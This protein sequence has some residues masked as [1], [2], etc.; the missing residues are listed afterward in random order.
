MAMMP[1]AV[2]EMMGGAQAGGMPPEQGAPQGGMPP[3]QA[4]PTEPPEQELGDDEL[5]G[6]LNRGIEAVGQALYSNRELSD[7]ILKMVSDKEKIGSAA[8]AAIL[9][10][11]QVDKK[12]D[13]DE[14]ALAGLTVWTVGRLIE[15][16]EA[17]SR[18][19][20]EY[21]DMET[22]QVLM[23]SIELLFEAYGVTLED[24]QALASELDEGELNQ[25]EREYKETL[26]G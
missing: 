12:I 23:T 3:E 18:N 25:Y 14:E 13:L 6:E 19:G 11:T 15:L 1:P 2:E 7:K 9:T 21:T 8:K 26:N 24:R 20:L 5:Q 4:M 10:V 17:D 22:K 16:V